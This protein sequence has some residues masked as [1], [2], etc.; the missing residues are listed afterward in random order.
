MYIHFKYTSNVYNDIQ[1]LNHSI[2][3]SFV[4]SCPHILFNVLVHVLLS[5]P[6]RPAKV[7]IGGDS[8]T[9]DVATNVRPV[10]RERC[11]RIAVELN[12]P[13]RDVFGS[14]P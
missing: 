7:I 3:P 2:R 11:N 4:A 9:G 10:L 5:C 8:L 6:L 12:P 14:C 1:H 13:T